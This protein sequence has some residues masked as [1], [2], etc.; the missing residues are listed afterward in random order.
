MIIV[1][2]IC[3]FIGMM[4]GWNTPMPPGLLDLQVRIIKFFNHGA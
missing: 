3:L 1:A 4:I 2:I